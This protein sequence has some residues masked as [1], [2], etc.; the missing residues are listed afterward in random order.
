MIRRILRRAVRY[1]YSFL[2]VKEPFLHKMVTLVG[3]SFKDI[4]PEVKQKQDFV[5]N[6]V[7]EEEIGFLRTL[8]RGILK[9]NEIIRSNAGSNTNNKLIN[10]NEAFE[11]L[12]TFGFPIDL[13][14]LIAK[15][16]GFEVDMAG[17][18]TELQKQKERSRK[19]TAIETNDW[20]ILEENDDIKFT[21]YDELEAEIKIMRYRKVKAK[22]KEQFQLVFNQTPFYAES[23][24][25]VGDT[26]IITSANEK[27]NIVDT[28]KENNLIIHIANQLPENPGALFTAKVDVHKRK[29]T[30]A[31]H[32]ATHLL[33]AALRKVLGTHVEQKGSLVNPEYLRFDF[34]H[35]KAMSDEEIAKVEQ[36]VNQKIR[37]NIALGERRN[38]PIEEAKKLGAMA[39]FGE[40]Y[41]DSVRVITFDK[42]SFAGARM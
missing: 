38:V 29:L 25:Q 5:E 6:V 4:F 36:L 10:G 20:I 7:R 13:T 12:D 3:D 33:H 26:G 41:G 22:G 32:S 2:D 8:E 11:L 1:Y 21:G 27:I 31:N 24:G 35:F 15:E 42:A 18:E 23:G 34:S 16:N 17:F 37:E 14:Q 19:A 28:Q 9:M 39:L 40:K 30:E